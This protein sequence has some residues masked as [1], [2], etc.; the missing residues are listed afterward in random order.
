MSKDNGTWILQTATDSGKAEYRV[1]QAHAIE[2]IVNRNGTPNCRSLVDYFDKAKIFLDRAEAEVYALRIETE[3]A[4]EYG[5]A[6][7]RDFMDYFFEDIK[8]RANGQNVGGR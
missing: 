8:E 3:V 1:I 4:S 7:I 6:V 2:N 5:V